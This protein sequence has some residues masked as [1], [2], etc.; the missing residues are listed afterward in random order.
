MPAKLCKHEGC[1]QPLR[2]RGMCINHYEVWRRCN[3]GFTMQRTTERSILAEM[4]A[5]RQQIMRNTGHGYDALSRA[6]EVLLNSEPAQAHIAGWEPP[7]TKGTK[8]LPIYE[9]GPGE[10][11]KAPS[12]AKRKAHHR[13]LEREMHARKRTTEKLARV[14]TGAGWAASLLAG[15]KTKGVE[16]AEAA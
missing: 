9:A 1:G 11:A 5:T 3:P 2:A 4:P 12:A 6:L 8:W 7:T 10:N 13:M 16:D 15:L 14:P